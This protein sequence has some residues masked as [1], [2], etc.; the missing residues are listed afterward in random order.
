MQEELSNEAWG[1]LKRRSVRY[2]G[3]ERIAISSRE[4]N[5]LLGEI[6]KGVVAREALGR[7]TEALQGKMSQDAWLE[8]MTIAAEAEELAGKEPGLLGEDYQ[9]ALDL[10]MCESGELVGAIRA[11]M[12]AKNKWFLAT[13]QVEEERDELQE[14][15][16]VTQEAMSGLGE[17]PSAERILTA[18]GKVRGKLA[19]LGARKE[20]EMVESLEDLLE[21]LK[22]GDK[23]QSNVKLE[24]VKGRIEVLKKWGVKDEVMSGASQLLE[25]VA[26]QDMEYISDSMGN[27]LSALEARQAEMRRGGA[28]PG[29]GW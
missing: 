12:T 3:A 19:V 11:E 17:E 23:K 7:I 26:T 5:G 15:V 25:A 16:E 10:L 2:Q 13:R 28:V 6:E 1:D 8:M 22:V 4:L 29:W 9:K 18:L 24:E 14:V 27:V 21:A 20:D